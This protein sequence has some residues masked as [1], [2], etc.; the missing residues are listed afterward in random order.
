MLDETEKGE[1]ENDSS[2]TNN[3]SVEWFESRTKFGE[4]VRLW[5]VRL[6]AVLVPSQDFYG[7]G[8]WAG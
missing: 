5:E 8:L 7:E 1:T 6:A 3:D 4:E 2:C